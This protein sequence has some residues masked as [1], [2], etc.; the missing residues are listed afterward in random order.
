MVC[1]HRDV[2][3]V[4]NYIPARTNSCLCGACVNTDTFKFECVLTTHACYWRGLA[5]GCGRRSSADAVYSF[6][7][8][9][10]RKNLCRTDPVSQIMNI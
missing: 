8:L 6:P 3:K 4:L 5:H 7:P 1:V 2:F 9:T 10:I